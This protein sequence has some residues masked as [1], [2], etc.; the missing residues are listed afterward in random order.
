MKIEKNMKRK[1]WK[2]NW[3][4]NLIKKKEKEIEEKFSKKF[5]KKFGKN[6]WRPLIFLIRLQVS[7]LSLIVEE[8]KHEDLEKN[9]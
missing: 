3:K 6:S 1:S 2:K 4:E 9:L 5:S 7:L 8:D